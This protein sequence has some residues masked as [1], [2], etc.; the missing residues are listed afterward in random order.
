[1]PA[2]PLITYFNAEFGISLRYPASWRTEQA[3]QGDIWYRYFLGPAGSGGKPALSA[4][5]LAGTLNG[6]LDA[7]AETY[8]ANNAPGT[9]REEM[10]GPARGRSYQ[11][12]SADGKTRYALL[13]LEEKGR[14]FG[15]YCQ[16]DPAAFE[17]ARGLLEEMGLSLTLERA[18]SYPETR[19]DKLGFSIRL[20]PSWKQTRRFAGGGTELFQFTSPPLAVDKG[21]QTVHASLTLTLEKAP[22][23]GG[24]QAYYDAARLKL[25]EAFKVVSHEPWRTG[26]VD[27]M[28][29]ETPISA[30]RVKRFYDV[31]GSR[32]VSLAFEA[33]SD[34]FGRV[35]RWCDLIASTLE[36]REPSK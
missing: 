25:G 34:V 22:A 31:T 15:L 14:V 3:Q 23:S 29:V 32:G 7:Y 9:S 12:A 10:R 16:G 18:E 26:F 36:A 28:S 21:G 13:L 6:A 19:D 4:T 24:A 1:M 35:S 11:Y 30:S 17:A 8:L 27:V 33:R 2:E 20:P 5:L